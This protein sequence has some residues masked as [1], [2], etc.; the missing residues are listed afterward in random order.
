MKSKKFLFKMIL[1]LLSV[2]VLIP[3]LVFGVIF[4][5]SLPSCSKP[6][7]KG[8]LFDDSVL[9]KYSLQFL[10]RPD[11]EE[12]SQYIGDTTYYYTGYIADESYFTEYVE[13]QFGGF[14]S[15]DNT[16]ACFKQKVYADMLNAGYHYLVELSDNLSDYVND[17]AA[18]DTSY[19]FFY[20]DKPTNDMEF[21]AGK[22]YSMG[23]GRLE[24]TLN[25]RGERCK[26]TVSLTVSH[27]TNEYPG[28]FIT[29]I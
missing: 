29:N 1:L 2:I 22:G 4:L 25:N 5:F 7:L 24:I 6:I 21:V 26:I 27:T 16:Y 9:K 20:S 8:N 17:S 18:P 11:A 19:L 12:E 23:D 15:S 3:I 28:A 13:R 14:K 10:E